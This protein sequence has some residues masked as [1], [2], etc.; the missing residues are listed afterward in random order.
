MG[1][2][3][4]GSMSEARDSFIDLH[5]DIEIVINNARETAGTGRIKY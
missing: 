3:D 1:S 4:E 5:T 2:I